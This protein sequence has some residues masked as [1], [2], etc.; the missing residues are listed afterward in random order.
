MGSCKEVFQP[1]PRWVCIHSSTKK[2]FGT[3]IRCQ[4]GN[5]IG[6]SPVGV[7]ATGPGPAL[8]PGLQRM[9]MIIRPD[10]SLPSD[11]LQL[12]RAEL[13]LATIGD[14]SISVRRLPRNGQDTSPIG[15]YDLRIVVVRL[16]VRRSWGA[17]TR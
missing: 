6:A 12:S 10:L 8:L 1:W 3:F 2:E 14:G 15:S 11:Q 5:H 17:R 16:S 9:P 13:G 7:L 4:R